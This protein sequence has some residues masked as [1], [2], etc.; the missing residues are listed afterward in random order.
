LA[1]IV[2]VALPF[3]RFPF[4]FRLTFWLTSEGELRIEANR[5]HCQAHLTK[6]PRIGQELWPIFDIGQNVILEWSN[7]DFPPEVLAR[8]S[9]AKRAYAKALKEDAIGIKRTVLA[10]VGP[11]S[12]GKTSLIQSL[13]NEPA[14]EETF[15]PTCKIAAD[16]QWHF[17]DEEDYPL[18]IDEKHHKAKAISNALRL[19]KSSRSTSASSNDGEESSKLSFPARIFNIFNGKNRVNVAELEQEEEHEEE[20]VPQEVAQLAEEQLQNEDSIFAG[21]WDFPH[22]L[23]LLDLFGGKFVYVLVFD[24]S[25]DL[26][27]DEN[28]YLQE[29]LSWLAI[30][31]AKAGPSRG[32]VIV[33]GTKKDM[34]H[35]VPVM[36]DSMVTKK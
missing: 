36:Q 28:G 14:K 9:T 1:R 16:D 34:L 35:P 24:L 33:V 17:L 31:Q 29:L 22:D 5:R 19:E 10:F 32:N 11:K 7:G 15:W 6:L 12:C 3:S 23:A 4:I 8:G 20:E 18:S 21:I 27:Q 26:T 2:V 25:V 13:L 30:L